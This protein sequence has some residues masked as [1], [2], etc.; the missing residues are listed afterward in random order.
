[1]RIADHAV[2]PD[3]AAATPA[4]GVGIDPASWL[5]RD[6]DPVAAVAAHAADLVS[7]RLCDDSRLDA[8]A[9]LAALRAEAYR[10]PVVAD[11]RRCADPWRALTEIADLKSQI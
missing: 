10:G 8:A 2:P 1:V 5:D 11:L 3:A 7:V 9:Y 4:I 6:A